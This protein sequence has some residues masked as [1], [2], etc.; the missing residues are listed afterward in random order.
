MSLLRR[1]GAEALNVSSSEESE[2]SDVDDNEV[3]F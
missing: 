1:K 2:D 3:S